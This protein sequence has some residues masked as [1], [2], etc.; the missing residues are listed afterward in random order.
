MTLSG[1]LGADKARIGIELAM[2]AIFPPSF[3]CVRLDWGA[4][5]LNWPTIL[6]LAFSSGP[7]LKGAGHLRVQFLW[8]GSWGIHGP[9]QWRLSGCGN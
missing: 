7:G 3:Q 9:E 4:A 2:F 6:T 5:L 8:I 1:V